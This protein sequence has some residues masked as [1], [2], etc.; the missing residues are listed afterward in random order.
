MCEKLPV[1]YFISCSQK[2][3]D[4]WLCLYPF[5]DPRFP[6]H[7]KD[8]TTARMSIPSTVWAVL[9]R[10]VTE[11]PSQPG[12]VRHSGP[13]RRLECSSLSAPNRATGSW[14]YPRHGHCSCLSSNHGNGV[15]RSAVRLTGGTASGPAVRADRAH[16]WLGLHTPGGAQHGPEQQRNATAAGTAAG[17]R[18]KHMSPQRGR[19]GRSAGTPGTQRH[20]QPGRSSNVSPARPCTDQLALGGGSALLISDC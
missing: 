17:G 8:K 2:V 15:T 9:T 10:L 19:A 7:S 5:S 3:T 1:S 11:W 6:H 4:P 18:S 12:C 14:P 20:H 13:T 16:P